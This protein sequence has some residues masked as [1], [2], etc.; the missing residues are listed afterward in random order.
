VLRRSAEHAGARHAMMGLLG[1]F[2]SLAPL[3]ARLTR[4]S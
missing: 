4:I 3:A 2:P 1:W